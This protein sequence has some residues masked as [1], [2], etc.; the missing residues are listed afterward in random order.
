MAEYVWIDS[1]G[2]TR[3]KSRVSFFIFCWPT[4][5]LS[6]FFFLFDILARL[7]PQSCFQGC[8]TAKTS[9]SCHASTTRA[10]HMS[11]RTRKLECFNA[12]VFA[13]P[14]RDKPRAVSS[15]SPTGAHQLQALCSTCL[16][17]LGATEIHTPTLHAIM[18]HLIAFTCFCFKVDALITDYCVISFRP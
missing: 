8:S 17:T 7:V 14:P 3:S 11:T 6:P 16:A 13:T 18:H 9:G 2:E 5:S 15:S 10:I 1:I 12:C 4:V